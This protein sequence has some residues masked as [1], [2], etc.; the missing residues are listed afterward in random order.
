[1]ICGM[2]IHTKNV[3]KTLMPA[4]QRK[5]TKHA[6]GAAKLAHEKFGAQWGIGVGLQG[7]SYAIPTMDGWFRLEFYA[8]QFLFFA[9]L[10]PEFTFLLTPIGTGI[11]GYTY[12]D[13]EPL[14]KDLP[15]NVQ[16]VGWV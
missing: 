6:G 5:M 12:E 2:T 7:N 11:A 10:N 3:I 4:G 1:M 15:N 16:K 13:I 8:K 14:F 9:Q